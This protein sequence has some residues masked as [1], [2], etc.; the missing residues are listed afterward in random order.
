M[1]S[2]GKFESAAAVGIAGWGVWSLHTAYT[3]M[4]PGLSTLRD[5]D[6]STDTNT[7]QK[8]LDA[9][10]T[11]G[12]LALLAGGFA[13]YLMGSWLPLILVGSAFGILCGYHHL[14]YSGP[15]VGTTSTPGDSA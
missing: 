3:N 13:S 12:S 2:L 11:V 1:T 5:S 14:A 8:L 10:V 9:D 7:A 15:V 4:A 6:S